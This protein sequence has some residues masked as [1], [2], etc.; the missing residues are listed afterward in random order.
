M[1]ELVSKQISIE[2]FYGYFD[3]KSKHSNFEIPSYILNFWVFFFFSFPLWIEFYNEKKKLFIQGLF[4]TNPNTLKTT[5]CQ[6]IF[7]ESE[8]YRGTWV[9]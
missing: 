1:P 9:A 6:P 3:I 4:G 5:C 7:T 8:V 2:W